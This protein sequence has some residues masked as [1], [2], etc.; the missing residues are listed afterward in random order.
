MLKNNKLPG[1]KIVRKLQSFESVGKVVHVLR[2]YQDKNNSNNTNLFR[3]WIWPM[4]VLGFLI[5]SFK[6]DYEEAKTRA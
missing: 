5:F 4:G 3:F 2:T 1:L 6:T